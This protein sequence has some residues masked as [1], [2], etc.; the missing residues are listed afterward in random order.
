[1]AIPANLSKDVVREPYYKEYM[2]AFDGN[3]LANELIM[4]VVSFT[5]VLT[6]TAG[7]AI[8]EFEGRVC[9]VVA[10]GRLL[11]WGDR[12]W[13]LKAH[14]KKARQASSAVTDDEVLQPMLTTG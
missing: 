11:G 8:P 6:V 9:G 1:V 12:S 14:P 10:G 3:V 13:F 7:N 5:G 4:M 2:D